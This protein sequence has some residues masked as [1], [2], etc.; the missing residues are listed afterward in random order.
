MLLHACPGDTD[1]VLMG[2]GLI[3][4]KVLAATALLGLNLD[5]FKVLQSQSSPSRSQNGQGE[6]FGK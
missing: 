6:G 5:S 4:G 1:D 2:S 3:D